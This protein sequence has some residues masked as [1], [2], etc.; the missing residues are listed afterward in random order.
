MGLGVGELMRVF[1]GTNFS[2][3]IKKYWDIMHDII[4][5]INTNDG[6]VTKSCPTLAI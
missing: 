6:L 4:P 5:V 2:Y 1:K 3:K